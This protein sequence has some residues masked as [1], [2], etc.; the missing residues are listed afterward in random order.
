LNTFLRPGGYNPDGC[1]KLVVMEKYFSQ[2]AEDEEIGRVTGKCHV[3]IYTCICIYRRR[4]VYVNIDIRVVFE[5]SHPVSDLSLLGL[6][7][8][9]GM[10]VPLLD[11]RH[12]GMG[13]TWI[14]LVRDGEA[15]GEVSPHNLKIACKTLQQGLAC[16]RTWQGLVCITSRD[17]WL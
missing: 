1:L 14:E 12:G 15:A 13:P 8:Y 4:E 3:H 11:V 10:A 9:D 7:Y 16:I 2:D 5:G 17:S 6:F